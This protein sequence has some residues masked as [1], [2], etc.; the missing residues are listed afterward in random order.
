LLNQL[1]LQ[2]ITFQP[3]ISYKISEMF[4][5]GAGLTYTVGSV[6]LQRN[7]DLASAG[8]E[9]NVELDGSASGIGFNAGVY[10]TPYDKFSVGLTYRSKTKMTVEGGDAI[11]NVPSS[12]RPSFPADNKFNASL[13]L[14]SVTSLG[15]AY[16][17]SEKLT[18]G[19]DVNFSAWSAYDSLIFEYEKPLQGGAITR[20]ASPRNYKD[21]FAFRLGGQYA[22]TDAFTVRAGGYYDMTPVRDG[23]MTPETPD[24]DR[25]GLSAGV[26]YRIG[27]F[28]IDAS[29][30]FING[31]KREQTQNQMTVQNLGIPGIRLADIKTPG[32]GLNNEM[33]FNPFYERLL[34]DGL[35]QGAAIYLQTSV[36]STPT[37][38][39]TWLGN[40]DVLGFATNGG[41]MDKNGT[42]D[43]AAITTATTFRSLYAEFLD[44]VSANKTKKGAIAN[45]P[46]VTSVPMFTTIIV[47]QLKATAQWS[48][49]CTGC[50]YNYR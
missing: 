21:A 35:P 18:V 7:L 13:P 2:A 4:G 34:P 32:Y 8:G 6:N 10:Y 36:A 20:T 44:V 25:I 17:P 15:I 39:T 48:Q 12:L 43:Y 28:E 46:Y 38:F 49:S 45:I 9:G 26:G 31:M 41:D 27:G 30:L 1:S 33:G 47:T 50:L 42:T 11:F 24:S 29:V 19:F 22:V 40:N 16:K 3:T 23:Y 37:F 14:V 5:I